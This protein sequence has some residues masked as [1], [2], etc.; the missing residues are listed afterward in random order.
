MRPA[1]R[2]DWGMERWTWSGTV[3]VLVAMSQLGC[4]QMSRSAIPSVVTGAASEHPAVTA[5]REVRAIAPR[6]EQAWPRFNLAEQTLFI[7]LQPAGPLFMAGDPS[8]PSEFSAIDAQRDVFRRNGAP[9]AAFAGLF[10]IGLDWN[11]GRAN[12]TSVTAPASQWRGFGR[13]NALSTYL[14]HEAVH[15]FQA[16][17]RIAVPGSFPVGG[18]RPRFPDS[19]LINVAL[20]NLEG[21]FLAR[22]LRASNPAAT[23][24]LARQ[25][26]AARAR[27]CGFLG[28][29]EC[30]AEEEI[31]QGEGMA[32]YITAV[33]TDAIGERV[34]P[35]GP[36][37]DTLANALSPVRDLRRLGG[38]H[39][40]D[41]GHA[42]II[43]LGRIAP[44]SW[45]ERV[46]RD[47]PS[48]VLA[49][50]L[51]ATVAE[52]RD[53]LIDI[54]S[55]EWTEAIRAAQTAI[56]REHARKDSAERA[57]WARPGVAIRVYPGAVRST[58]SDHSVAANGDV[59]D[60]FRFDGGPDQVTF[61]TPS[62]SAC[63][64]ASYVVV[65]PVARRSVTVDGGAIPLDRVGTD[66]V[67]AVVLELRDVSVR[68]AR[69]RI[70]VFQD[71]VTIHRQ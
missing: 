52:S 24:Q 32:Q 21:S 17:R 53:S 41:T 61:R 44:A 5:L 13:S 69:A 62:R 18:T 11:G 43:L 20:I 1:K 65:A 60:V 15:T 48:R 64:P 3:T 51:N 50:V 6:A 46:E 56:S 37:R 71:S 57:F 26:L 2:G 63:C 34:P 28:A 33:L 35:G 30:S 42:W 59:E 45:E 39:Y 68:F 36:W 19:V 70:R 27:R 25:A 49:A 67:G 7:A 47:P 55:P 54:T 66:A 10:Q 40:Y 58:I 29:E 8:P 23:R 31:E 14:V 38:L 16:Q 9:P 4:G 22:A 12:A